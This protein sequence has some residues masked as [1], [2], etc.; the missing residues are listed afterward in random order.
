[1]TCL[2]LAGPAQ[3]KDYTPLIRFL[4]E[5]FACRQESR[6]A[7]LMQDSFERQFW[8]RGAHLMYRGATGTGAFQV[9]QSEAAAGQ[10]GR[11]LHVRAQLPATTDAAW[12]GYGLDWELSAAPF[13][14][15]DRL[16]FKLQG[17]ASTRRLHDLAKTGSGSA[18]MVIQGD[19]TRQE[20]RIFVVQMESTGAVGEATFQWSKDGGV[21]WEA[22]GLISGDREHPVALWAGLA[23]YWEGGSGTQLVAGDYWTFWAGEPASHPLRL[24]VS[25]NDSTPDLPDPWDPAHTYVHAIPDRFAELTSF[26][27]PF[28]Q[29]WRRDNLIDDVDRVS[30]IWGAWYSVSQQELSDLTI[31]TREVTE[32]LEGETFYS[33]R[34]V[35]WDLSPNT[36][37]FG[38]WAAIDPARC[39]S[40][41]QSQVNFLIRAVVAG[42]SSLT[43]RVKL[44]DAQGS[45]FPGCDPAGQRLAAGDRGPGGPA[46]GI[47]GSAPDPPL[48]GD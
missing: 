33:Q 10:A 27:V 22:T 5:A 47:G 14:G 21:T 13:N 4:W 32:V 1:M 31:G 41:G 2:H 9:F 45:Y 17:T 30:T 18:V 42:V 44:K 26:E 11:V 38:V 37:A 39:D 36:T 12:F 8:D 19:Y 25:L 6:Q 24:L 28:S 16:S 23:V 7:P 29:F 35:T 43:L 3:G 48:P 34:L 40:T 15:I 46:T 20:K